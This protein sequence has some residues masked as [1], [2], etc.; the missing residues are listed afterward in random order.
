MMSRLVRLRSTYQ[1][2]LP[3]HI[4][5]TR[6]QALHAMF[7]TQLGEPIAWTSQQ[8]GNFF[9]DIIPIRENEDKAIS[10]GSQNLFDLHT[11]DAALFPHTPDYL[12]LMGLRRS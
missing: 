10:S 6:E 8:S 4:P 12:G 11:E 2:E 5:V 9:N 7:A 1:G 3:K